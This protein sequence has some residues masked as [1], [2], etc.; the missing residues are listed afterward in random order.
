MTRKVWSGDGATYG[1]TGS[2]LCSVWHTTLAGVTL[3]LSDRA[4]SSCSG[5]RFRDPAGTWFWSISLIIQCVSSVLPIKRK[6]NAKSP[7][8]LVSFWTLAPTPR[9]ASFFQ[10]NVISQPVRPSL[11]AESAAPSKAVSPLLDKTRAGDLQPIPQPVLFLM[12]PYACWGA[13]CPG[14]SSIKVNLGILV[15]L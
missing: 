13:L 3:V 1:R 12:C 5:S 14:H 9:V 6:H 15:I 10:I 4:S 7:L 8:F 2:L 11:R